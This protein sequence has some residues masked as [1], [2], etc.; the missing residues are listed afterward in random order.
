MAFTSSSLLLRVVFDTLNDFGKKLS[1]LIFPNRLQN[2]SNVAG[3]EFL[4]SFGSP[5]AGGQMH[6]PS[7]CTSICVNG[8][9]PPLNVSVYQLNIGTTNIRFVCRMPNSFTPWC[10]NT[11]GVHRTPMLVTASMMT[12]NLSTESPISPLP[13]DH[14]SW[15]PTQ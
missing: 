5:I 4:L 11:V 3:C 2:S 7:K 1:K 13:G 14:N 15:F 9:V 10:V 8:L 12:T 6:A